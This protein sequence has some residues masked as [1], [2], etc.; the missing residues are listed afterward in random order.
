MW[1]QIV[2]KLSSKFAKHD[3]ILSTL[4][5]CA[6]HGVIEELKEYNPDNESKGIEDG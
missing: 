4:P 6:A 2:Y 1:V 3:N 5:A